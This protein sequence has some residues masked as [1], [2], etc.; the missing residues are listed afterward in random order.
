MVI[1]VARRIV[2]CL[3]MAR[4]TRYAARRDHDLIGDSDGMDD[5]RREIDQV[6]DLD[7]P[8]LLR[9]ET[10]TGKGKAAAALVAASARAARPSLTINMGATVPSTA[11]SELFGHERG[12]FTGATVTKPGL[13][14][15]A[16]T[17]SLF[18]DEIGLT[19]ADVQPMLLHVLDSG[20]IRP[21]GST[22]SRKVDV[23][24]IAGTDSDLERAI[25]DGRFSEAL[26]QRVARYP[27][28]D[29]PSPRLARGLRIAL[30]PLSPSSL[31]QVQRAEPAGRSPRGCPAVA[32]RIGRGGP[33]FLPM[34]GQRA[35]ARERRRSNRRVQPG[36]GHRRPPALGGVPR[37]RE[38]G[39][40][41]GPIAEPAPDPAPSRISDEQ[42]ADA[43][44]RSNGNASRAAAVLKVSR[45]T[46]YELRKRNP[47]LRSVNAIPEDE[48]IE[49][50]GVCGGDVEL[51]AQRLRVP[52]KAL[53]DRL[54][55]LARRR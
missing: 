49:C 10:G 20:E 43:L 6:A 48:L 13:F 34:D 50:Q 45:T 32:L 14:A 42:V 35:R 15:T 39:T 16:D 9:G 12:S 51:M 47:L 33:G 17:G 22:V 26:F 8:V 38:P 19:P 5:I 18:L 3:H 7:V 28:L 1:T 25:A 4:P 24:F 37:L 29:P 21:L 36:K 52:V 40:V 46:F 11:A 44:A 27:I 31:R 23:R 53:K 30:H 54:A 55:H 41:P 2:L